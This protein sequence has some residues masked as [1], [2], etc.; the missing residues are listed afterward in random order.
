MKTGLPLHVPGS[1]VR[2]L[3]AVG[4][5]T[6]PGR[7]LAATRTAGG[8]RFAGAVGGAFVV[9]VVVVV[10]LVDVTVAGSSGGFGPL[11]VPRYL[12]SASVRARE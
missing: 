12:S 9:V 5:A 4:R 1:Q 2:A 10:V 7:R 8:V 6:R 3:P 11:A